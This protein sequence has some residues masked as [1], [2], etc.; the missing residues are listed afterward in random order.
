MSYKATIKYE[1]KFVKITTQKKALEGEFTLPEFLKKVRIENKKSL[2]TTHMNTD[3]PKKDCEDFENGKQR[4]PREYLEMF[5]LAYKLPKKIEILGFVQEEDTKKILAERLKQLRTNKEMPQ[6]LMA[7]A[8]D[9]SRSTYASY[10]TG[11][12]EPDI[13]TLI[14][15]ADFFKVSLDYLV[16][17]LS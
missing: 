17:R 4:I 10:E 14:K 2:D 5:T 8:I 1:N 16:G 9:V 15:I 13:H 7:A 6:F 3:F 12:N 11:R